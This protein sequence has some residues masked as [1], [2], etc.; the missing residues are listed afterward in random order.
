MPE[1][2]ISSSQP[3]AN[4]ATPPVRPAGGRVNPNRTRTIRVPAGFLAVGH[5][6]GVH[7]LR[8][9]LK[10]DLYTDFPE[11]FVP[12]TSLFVGEEL[13]EF[14]V[15]GAR[16]HQQHLLLQLTGIEGRAEAEALRNIWLFVDEADAVELESGLYWVH[17]IIG[18]EVQTEDGESLGVVREVLF[19]GANEVYV[20]ETPP[21]VNKG[22]DLLLP[23][24]DEVVREVDL[25]A[26]R[27][28]VHLLPG[29]LE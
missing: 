25:A 18:L 6:V 23:A 5:I 13:K 24:I 26:H 22:N 12:G 15:A 11:R 16:M 10:V 7:G 14:R 17:D 8:G 3:Q 9:E 19:T 4:R 27:I 21:T 28:T 1:Q 29:L 20:V 2:S